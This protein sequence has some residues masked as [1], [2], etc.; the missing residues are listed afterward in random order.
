MRTFAAPRHG[1]TLVLGLP[2]SRRVIMPRRAPQPGAPQKP[3]AAREAVGEGAN[4]LMNGIGEQEWKA[5]HLY[6]ATCYK[7]SKCEQLSGPFQ[8]TFPC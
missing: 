6:C 1:G 8:I 2:L 3:G 7:P 5:A 4:N